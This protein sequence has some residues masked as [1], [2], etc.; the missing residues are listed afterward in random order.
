MTSPG[1]HAGDFVD[2]ARG[3]GY[4]CYAGVPCSFLT[5]FINY[6]INDRTL[7]YV[8][9]ANEGDAVAIAAGTWIGGGRGVAMMQN[10]GLGN[11]ISPLTSLT[12]TFRIPVLVIC[13]HRG[14][15]GIKDEPQH[16]LMGRI[17]ETMFD[18]IEIPWTT[19]PDHRAAIPPAL[20]KIEHAA[21]SRSAFGLILRGGVIAPCPLRPAAPTPP[22]PAAT[23]EGRG[24]VLAVADRPS[25]QQALEVICAASQEA[26]Q[27]VIATTGYT[28][29]ELSAIADRPNH[30][31]MVG[32]MG[33]ASSL[34]LGLALART[35][36]QVIV[37]DGDGATL[38]RM[39]NLAT[40][41][42]YAP[43]NLTHV[44]LDNEAHDS[45][46]GQST[47]SA[48]VDFA[49]VAAACGYRRVLRTDS[50]TELEGFL[51]APAGEGARFA[52]LKIRTGTSDG[53]P[54]PALKPPE[55]LE[56]LM[57]H[58]GSIG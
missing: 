20:E 52:H 18:T 31:Y 37:A 17:T 33:C 16:T 53:L 49:G 57:S 11:A 39:G 36:L 22:P 42:A 28:G 34:A 13:T 40:V 44:L 48:R 21:Q 7:G 54:R 15:P 5:P 6:V 14:R 47:V 26:S 1:I 23:I 45:T 12:H 51:G 2:E 9:A 41:G 29:R 50:T 19:F 3:R 58:I 25:R 8:S 4:N 27:V 38:M 56:R 55:V 32:S 10:S 30:L 24:H 43:P 46:G 35:D